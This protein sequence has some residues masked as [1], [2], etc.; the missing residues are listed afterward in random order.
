MNKDI[1]DIEVKNVTVVVKPE[2]EGEHWSV[3][4]VNA[5]DFPIKDILVASTGYAEKSSNQEKTSTIRQFFDELA[6]KDSVQIELI[7]PQVFHLFNEYGVTY[8]IDKEIYFKKYVF[9]PDS[10]VRDNLRHNQV[11]DTEVVEHS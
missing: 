2:K 10:I 7:D 11:M 9:V 1:P 4:L 5:N 3:H 6:G 8:Y